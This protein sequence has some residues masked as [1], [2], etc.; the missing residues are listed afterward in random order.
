MDW[1]GNQLPPKLGFQIQSFHDI[2]LPLPPVSDGKRTFRWQIFIPL[3]MSS[4]KVLFI[5]Q[6]GLLF[7]FFFVKGK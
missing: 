5:L 6:K 3:G 4:G 1:E 2:S 7:F